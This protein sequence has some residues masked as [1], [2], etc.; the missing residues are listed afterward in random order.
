[1]K[2]NRQQQKTYSKLKLALEIKPNVLDNITAQILD[3]G[4]GKNGQKKI[5]EGQL[6]K[7]N[8][9]YILNK[10]NVNFPRDIDSYGLLLGDA[11]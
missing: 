7:L 6:R 5:F 11:C 1:M 10:I 8:M 4:L 3:S 2:N 9:N